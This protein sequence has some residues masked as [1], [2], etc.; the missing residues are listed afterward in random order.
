LRENTRDIVEKQGN[1]QRNENEVIKEVVETEDR[2][3]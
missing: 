3:R 2:Q 1:N